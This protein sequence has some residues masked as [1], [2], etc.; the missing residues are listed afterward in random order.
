[1]AG[2]GLC[3]ENREL[4][5]TLQTDTSNQPQYHYRE[6]QLL[7][8]VDYEVDPYLCESRAYC[9]LKAQGL[10]EQGHIPDFYGLIKGIDPKAKGWEPYLE[11]FVGD[12]VRPNA[13]VIE[14]IPNLQTF[15][16]KTYSTE[17]ADQL[18]TTLR[19]MHN[20]GVY[21]DDLETRNVKVQ[22]DTNRVLFL[23]F[24][25]AA[26][27]PLN[28]GTKREEQNMQEWMAS[29]NAILDELLVELVSLR[30]LSLAVQTN[31]Y[32][33]PKITKTAKFGGRGGGTTTQCRLLVGPKKIMLP[34]LPQSRRLNSTLRSRREPTKKI[35]STEMKI[36]GRSRR[37][38]E[39]R[40][41]RGCQ[42]G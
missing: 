33:R 27:F 31:F 7:D 40:T 23:D 41:P 38:W 34:Y 5:T 21:F 24:D 10:C 42:A 20:A 12:S 9:R 37:S 14:F 15:E 39:R 11:A 18:R 3:F 29:E 32:S 22:K 4:Q 28:S 16:L 2:E 25:H 8:P 1:M 6:K 36:L 17:G 30:S 35:R 13:V 19:Q 26:T